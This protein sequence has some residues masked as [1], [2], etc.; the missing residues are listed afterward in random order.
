MAAGAEFPAGDGDEYQSLCLKSRADHATE[1]RR[2]FTD[3]PNPAFA[4]IDAVGRGTGWPTL[5]AHLK[6]ESARDILF[7]MRAG[8]FLGYGCL[9]RGGGD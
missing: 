8:R 4:V 3:S 1:I 6:V 5:Q 7:A 2:I 9:R